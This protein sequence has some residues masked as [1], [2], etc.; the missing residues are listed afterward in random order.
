MSLVHR[1]RVCDHV[2]LANETKNKMNAGVESYNCVGCVWSVKICLLCISKG[3]SRNISHINNSHFEPGNNLIS[4][5]DHF[6]Y[7]HIFPEMKIKAGSVSSCMIL[8]DIS[9]D[10]LGMQTHCSNFLWVV[11]KLPQLCYLIPTT[12]YR[13]V[14]ARSYIC[15]R[16][17]EFIDF[18]DFFY[19]RNDN[20][21]NVTRYMQDKSYA[22]LYC[23]KIYDS[24]PSIDI[25]ADH[26][27]DHFVIGCDRS[28]LS[29]SLR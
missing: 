7:E 6:M 2:L 16:T 18:G 12:P 21:M 3:V 10:E 24:L 23:G 28:P 26:I 1:C 20:M 13:L 25:V 27:G 22:C 14:P 5:V 15:G 19:I 4:F 9:S 17:E 11:V 29:Q 8:Y